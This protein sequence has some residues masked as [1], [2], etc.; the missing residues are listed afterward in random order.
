MARS[1]RPMPKHT[2]MVMQVFQ[3]SVGKP[4]RRCDVVS[5][6]GIN[7]SAVA[8]SIDWLFAYGYILE[9]PGT[10]GGPT[11]KKKYGLNPR[12]PEWP[13]A[14]LRLLKV[15]PEPI[16]IAI[17]PPPTQNRPGKKR[18]GMSTKQQIAED[19]KKLEKRLRGS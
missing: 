14:N 18:K 3:K 17:D 11:P 15:I 8:K 6:S 7:S 13:P 12:H 19:L 10:A 5:K 16:P 2:E 4:L 1:K 9:L